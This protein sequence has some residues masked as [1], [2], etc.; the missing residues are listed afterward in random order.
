MR[1]R[2][3]KVYALFEKCN[4]EAETTRDRLHDVRGSKYKYVK[5]QRIKDKLSNRPDL[6]A[7]LLLDKLFPKNRDMIVGPSCGEL[8]LSIEFE[9]IERLLENQVVD[10][11]RCGVR[12]SYHKRSL[13]M[14][15]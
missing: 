13:Y 10:L 3:K 12:Y 4:C 7:F 11:V 6:H 8:W 15:A 1:R 2:S 5:F 9:D 14:Y